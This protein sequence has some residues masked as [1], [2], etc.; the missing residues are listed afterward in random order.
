MTT[1]WKVAE[2][3][4]EFPSINY[5]VDSIVAISGLDL[6]W[7]KPPLNFYCPMWPLGGQRWTDKKVS[8]RK[9]WIFF[10]DFCKNACTLLDWS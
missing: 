5:D 1:N 9:S 7:L 6:A 2:A 8:E 10:E 3:P 4:E